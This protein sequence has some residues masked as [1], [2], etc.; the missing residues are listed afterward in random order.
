M[1]RSEVETKIEN[2][3]ENKC[4]EKVVDKKNTCSSFTV[5]ISESSSKK[6]KT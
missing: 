4:E 5:S 3:E 2:T 1:S 6:I